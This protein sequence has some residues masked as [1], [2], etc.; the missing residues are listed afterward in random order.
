MFFYNAAFLNINS[1]FNVTVMYKSG[2][3]NQ[4]NATYDSVN[5][6]LVFDV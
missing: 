5:D 6:R 3:T 2:A 4:F 1:A